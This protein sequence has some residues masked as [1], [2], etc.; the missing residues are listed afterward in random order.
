MI[1][2]RIDAED[3]GENTKFFRKYKDTLKSRFDQQ[4]IWITA[5]YI[6]VI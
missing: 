1:R 4:D 5:Q 3:T 6:D 2:I